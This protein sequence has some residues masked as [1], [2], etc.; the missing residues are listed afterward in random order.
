MPNMRAAVELIRATDQRNRPVWINEALS[1]DARYVRQYLDFVDITGC[2]IY[3]VKAEDRRI[4][5]MAGATERWKKVGRGKPVYMVLQ[6][7]SWDEL[8]DYYGAKETAYPTFAESR[9]MAYDVIVH[10]AAGILYWGSRYLKSD[11]FRQSIYALTSEL[12]LLQPFLTASDVPGTTVLSIDLPEDCTHAKVHGLVRKT[13]DDWLVILINEDRQKHMAV[14]VDGVSELS[15]REL[16]LLYGQETLTATHGELIARL[17]PLDVKA[18]CTS[19]SYE[20]PRREGRQFG[21]K[22]AE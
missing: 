21:Q 8:G 6:G 16:H 3:P 5:R 17:Q 15:G 20:S 2:D 11:A 12:S 1:S 9:F 13:G 18:Y 10:G 19:R 7:F 22:G 4:E 14:V